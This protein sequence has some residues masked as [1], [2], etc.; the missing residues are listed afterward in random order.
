[1]RSRPPDSEIVSEG[2]L[3]PGTVGRL[4]CIYPGTLCGWRP[5]RKMLWPQSDEQFSVYRSPRREAL[6]ITSFTTD[7]RIREWQSLLAARKPQRACGLYTDSP[8]RRK[9]ARSQNSTFIYLGTALHSTQ[10]SPNPRHVLSATQLANWQAVWLRLTDSIGAIQAFSTTS[11]RSVGTNHSCGRQSCSVPL[12]RRNDD[13]LSV[14]RR[15]VSLLNGPNA[16]GL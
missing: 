11:S 14:C 13:R 16:C 4:P 15:M 3:V 7:G 12:T 10:E 1:M 2:G 6:E 9:H 5:D 8:T